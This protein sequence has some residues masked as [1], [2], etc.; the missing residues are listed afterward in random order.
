MMSDPFHEVLCRLRWS[1]VRGGAFYTSGDVE[2]PL[3][4]R[5]ACVIRDNP[6]TYLGLRLSATLPP[7]SAAGSVVE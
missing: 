4:A 1:S 7:C 3:S 6:S 5:R 2:R